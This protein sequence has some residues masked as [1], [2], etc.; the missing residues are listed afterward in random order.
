[1]RFEQIIHFWQVVQGFQ[2]KHSKKKIQG[3][4]EKTH[5]NVGHLPSQ[6]IGSPVQSTP[7]FPHHKMSDCWTNSPL[8]NKSLDSQEF[9]NEPQRIKI[10]SQ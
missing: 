8:S 9:I 1:M 10:S 6:L 2:F 3:D 5:L 7:N 4:N